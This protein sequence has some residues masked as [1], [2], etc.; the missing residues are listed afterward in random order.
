LAVR[1]AAKDSLLLFT[2]YTK[3]N[4]KVNWH[5]RVVCKY[6][7]KFVKGEIKKLMI[8]L[9]PQSGKALSI[10]ELCFTTKGWKKHGDLKVGDYVFGQDGKPK[11]VLANTGAYEWELYKMTFQGNVEILAS[12]EHLWQLRIEYDDSKGRRD[13][14]MQTKDIFNRRHRR[15]P[16]IDAAP[17][18]EMK[19]DYLPID[20]YVLGLWL[21]NGSKNS[22]DICFN[23][24]DGDTYRYLGDLKKDKTKNMYR[25]KVEGLAKLLADNG[26]KG[27]KHIPK[28][29]LLSSIEDRTRLLQGLMDT[30][31]HCDV[32]GRCEFCQKEGQLAEDCYVLIR[33][34]GYKT[35]K[36]YSRATLYGVDKGVRVRMLFSPDRD[37]VV[38]NTPRKADR[39]KNKTQVDRDDKKKFFLHSV[40]PLE[41]KHLVNCIEVEGGMYLAGVHMIPTH[42]SELST[43]RLSSYILG[44]DPSKRIAIAAYSQ[45]FASRFNR[46]IQKII[47]SPEYKNIFPNTVLGTKNSDVVRN[48]EE[49]GIVN[50]DG[51][52]KT[53]G[54]GAGLTGNPIDIGI[55][56]DP[57]KDDKEA[58]SAAYREGLWNWYESVFLTRLH[59]NSQQLITLTRW[60]E[61]DLAGRIL[62]EEGDEWVV[63]KLPAINTQGKSEDDPREIGEALWESQHSLERMKAMQ[64]SKFFSPMYQQEPVDDGGNILKKENFHIIDMHETPSGIIDI[65]FKFVGD[66]AYTKKQE[67]DPSAFAAYKYYENNL[68]IYDYFEGHY[69]MSRLVKEIKTFVKPYN[70]R[71]SKMHIEP[72]A[73]GLTAIQQLKLETQLNVIAWK[74]LEGDK[75]A[76]VNSIEAIVAAD[77]VFLIRGK[78]NA[79]FIKDCTSFPKV[80]H[81]EAPDLLVMMLDLN[82]TQGKKPRRGRRAKILR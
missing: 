62:E 10:N 27:N 57:I 31:G 49:F 38:F 42:N 47:D 16:Y 69:E 66:T 46:D 5:H 51:G 22:G 74:M 3:A 24:D 15:N 18:L 6:L 1:Q 56:D 59:N 35:S 75:V 45:T 80:K 30:D 37:D 44:K 58:Y 81:D 77:R 2:Q 64:K 41:G 43:R 26:L 19:G 13:A 50:Y 21:G 33:S 9:Q 12:P 68:Y 82:V 76:R 65:P 55:I 71:R 39:L 78:W 8:F 29:Y 63:L 79:K 54:V 72:K 53:V 70:S 32:K 73:S 11:K 34:L 36:I 52:L 25:V 28:E 20:P 40:E 17:A 23:G 60:H 67:N 7:D 14:L 48:N 61:D 4:Y